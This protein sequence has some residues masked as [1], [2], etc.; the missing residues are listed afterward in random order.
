MKIF[1]DINKNG[2]KIKICWYWNPKTK[3]SPV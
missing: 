3:I 1:E 2:K